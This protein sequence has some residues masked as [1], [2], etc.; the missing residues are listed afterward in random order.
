MAKGKGGKE[1][2]RGSG[3]SIRDPASPRSMPFSVF[4]GR[5]SSAM[6]NGADLGL[7][8]VVDRKASFYRTPR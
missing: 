3:W 2:W 8:T 7:D 5:F 1:E 4:A 6:T